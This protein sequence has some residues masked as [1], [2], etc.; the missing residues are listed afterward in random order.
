MDPSKFFFRLFLVDKDGNPSRFLGSAFTIAP[1]GGL[2]TC[3]HVVDVNYDRTTHRLAVLDTEIGFERR[4]FQFLG[5]P[6]YS[7]IMPFLDMAFIPDALGRPKTEFLPILTP[8]MLAVGEDVW[9]YGFRSPGDRLSP[10]YLSGHIANIFVSDRTNQVQSLL[11]PYTIIEGMSGSPVVSESYG[12]LKVVRLAHGNQMQRIVAREVIDY[13][14]TEREYKETINRIVEFGEAYHSLMIVNFL[15]DIGVD[16]A[17][18]SHEHVELPG[19][20]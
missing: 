2:L 13:K 3:K 12:G 9:T 19:L 6:I 8:Q 17:M 5:D 14:D 1:N 11:L 16:D 15:K 20:Q 18:V 7:T 10:T 4:D